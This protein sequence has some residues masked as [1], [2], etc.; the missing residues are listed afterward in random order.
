MRI[1]SHTL[2]GIAGLPEHHAEILRFGQWLEASS[3][4][5]L[6]SALEK[7]FVN[8]R[9]FSIILKTT[10]GGVI[11]GEGGTAGGRAV[12]RLKDVSGYKHEIARIDEQHAALA[13]D[14]RSSRA[15]L[16][17]LPMPVWLRA[18]DGRLIWVNTAYVNAVDAKSELEVLER[19]IELLETRQR[20][21]VA[22]VDRRRT[23]LQGPRPSRRR[24]RAQAPRHRRTAGRRHDG[25]SRDR[26]DRH[27]NRAGRTRSPD[28]GL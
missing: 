3:A 27:R 19:Q 21:A 26:R 18:P 16:N 14:I 24:R 20:K 12:L 5:A 22:K 6:K 4:Q 13:R 8:G 17:T 28:R 23:T 11:E 9:S 10:L 25:R 7:L 1:V 2:T 15:L